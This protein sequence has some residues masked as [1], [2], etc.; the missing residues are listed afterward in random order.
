MAK[1]AQPTLALIAH[2][3][4]KDAIAHFAQ[5][6]ADIL[7]RFTL[8]GTGSTAKAV[9]A[10]S[11]L[12]VEEMLSGPQGGDVQ[13]AARVAEGSVDCVIFLVNPL[14]AHPHDP[15]IQGLQRI[16]NVHDV[17]LATNLS[18]AVLLVQGIANALQNQKELPDE[19]AQTA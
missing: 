6:H 19:V 13:I 15:D 2:D 17:P 7:R 11:G 16:C 4:K 10:E 3:G 8:V 9:S 12:Q 14:D 18:S 1:K 5:E